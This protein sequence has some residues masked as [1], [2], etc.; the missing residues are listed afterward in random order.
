MS[1]F[2]C[3]EAVRRALKS[4]DR[5]LPLTQAL[6]LRF[7][8]LVCPPCA[9]FYRQLLFLHAAARGLDAR[10][11]ASLSPQARASIKRALQTPE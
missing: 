10:G 9:R 1:L 2:S 11:Q 4:F 6:T 7:H 8:R 3:K 5:A